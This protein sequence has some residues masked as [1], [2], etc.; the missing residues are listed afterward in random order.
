MG[1]NIWAIGWRTFGLTRRTLE[2]RM[3]G[4]TKLQKIAV[5]RNKI[6]DKNGFRM[7][8]CSLSM[9]SGARMKKNAGET[10]VSFPALTLYII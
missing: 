6:P 7:I 3:F 8:F 5:R 1:E 10:P 2:V 9:V 4:S